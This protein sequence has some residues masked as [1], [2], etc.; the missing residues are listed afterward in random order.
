MKKVKVGVFG[1]Y[2]GFVIIDRLIASPDAELVAVCERYEPIL[3]KVENRAKEVG[4][5][6]TCYNNFDDFI[7]HDMDAVVLAN[8]ATEHATFAVRCLDAGK[9]VLS[10]VLPAE[11]PAQAV[12]LIETVERTG[13]V[14][15]YAENYCY[16]RAPFEMHPLRARRHRRRDV[17]SAAHDYGQASCQRRRL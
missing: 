15:A 14:Y 3:E 17:R 1:G 9:H 5:E 2:R 10:E 4:I 16:I 11:T 7:K 6:V 13:L 8:Y 12:A